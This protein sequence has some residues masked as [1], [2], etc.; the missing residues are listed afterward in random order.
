M[1]AEIRIIYHDVFVWD[2]WTLE[3][4]PPPAVRPP[5]RKSPLTTG[6]MLLLLLLCIFGL[7]VLLSLAK[8]ASR[9]P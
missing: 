9:K 5:A 8:T 3:P 2:V 1:S 7:P 6:N 4:C